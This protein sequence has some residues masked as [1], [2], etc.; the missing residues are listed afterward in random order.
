MNILT[1]ERGTDGRFGWQ[2]AVVNI[3]DSLHQFLSG[4]QI[5]YFLRI[6][7]PVF[8]IIHFYQSF[9][10]LMF[11]FTIVCQLICSFKSKKLIQ[12][13]LIYDRYLIIYLIYHNSYKTFY[14]FHIHLY[15]SNTSSSAI[16]FQFLLSLISSFTEYHLPGR[17]VFPLFTLVFQ[18]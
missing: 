7:F 6:L 16:N 9:Q 14:S 4:N 18:S 2:S 1:A 12:C 10:V 17:K 5:L 3:L 15:L 11:L 8:P 13:F